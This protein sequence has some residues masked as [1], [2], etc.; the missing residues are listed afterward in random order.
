MNTIDQQIHE[1][2]EATPPFTRA[3][4]KALAKIKWTI[5]AANS[6]VDI[7]V[8][9]TYAANQRDYFTD[10][11]EKAQVFDGRDNHETRVK[12]WEEVTGE[13][14]GAVLVA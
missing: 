11:I 14:L 2:C 13:K 8:M 10:R 6:S 1:A 7:Y 12:F 9:K 5:K 4:S 3:R